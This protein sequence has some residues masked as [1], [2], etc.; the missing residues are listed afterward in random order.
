VAVAAILEVLSLED[1]VEVVA[2]AP[3]PA[4]FLLVIREL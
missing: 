3:P 4:G 1:R 2:M